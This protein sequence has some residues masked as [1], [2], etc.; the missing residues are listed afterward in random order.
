MVFEIWKI[1]SIWRKRTILPIL[2]IEK[3]S[4]KIKYGL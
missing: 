3:L 4:S 1:I 2:E